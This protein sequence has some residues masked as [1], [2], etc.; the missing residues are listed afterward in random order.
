MSLAAQYFSLLP[1]LL[2][3]SALVYVVLRKMAPTAARI[4]LALGGAFAGGF[5]APAV[6]VFLIEPFRDGWKN[7]GLFFWGVPIFFVGGMIGGFL[8]AL[9]WT[10]QSAEGRRK[11]NIA[12]SST[13]LLTPVV[14]F[15]LPNVLAFVLHDP[16]GDT[17]PHYL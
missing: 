5:L 9:R 17:M 7:F 10:A 2:A 14:L 3:L 8:A 4:S 15:L 6:F 13:F 16:R 1:F 11:L 12:L